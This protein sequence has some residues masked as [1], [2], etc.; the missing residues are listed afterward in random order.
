M[1]A[2]FGI[3]FIF[4]VTRIPERLAHGNRFLAIWFQSRHIWHIICI[5][6]ANGSL[7]FGLLYPRHALAG[8]HC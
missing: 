1:F 8:T 4:W 2:F 3:G 5:Y 6:I 7:Y